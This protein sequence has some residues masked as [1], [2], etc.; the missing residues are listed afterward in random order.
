LSRMGPSTMPSMCK[1]SV[2]VTS[3]LICMLAPRR[4]PPRDGAPLGFPDE[5]WLNGTTGVEGDSET[6]DGSAAA[7]CCLDHIIWYLPYWNPENKICSGRRSSMETMLFRAARRGN[8]ETQ[9]IC[10]VGKLTVGTGE[11]RWDRRM[12][13]PSPHPRGNVR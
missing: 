8:R 11:V 9:H 7:A 3:P 12:K 6:A 2:P 13:L 1:S 5:G 10:A 4:A